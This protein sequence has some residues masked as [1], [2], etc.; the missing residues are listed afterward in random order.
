[1]ALHSQF[2]KTAAT[3]LS[4]CP[5]E[6]NYNCRLARISSLPA[7]K[8]QISTTLLS[9]G[10]YTVALG[11]PTPVVND[12]DLTV[13][14]TSLKDV[15]SKFSVAERLSIKDF[16]KQ[17]LDNHP[18]APSVEIS[19]SEADA[20]HRPLSISQIMAS[21]SRSDSQT[22]IPE[23]EQSSTVRAETGFISK[24]NPT[25]VE[26]EVAGS[27]RFYRFMPCHKGHGGK[28]TVHLVRQYADMVVVGVLAIFLMAVAV[29]ELWTPASGR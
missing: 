16:L 26:E 19:H 23:M 10:L 12:K 13:P 2:W 4:H 7:N 6:Q 18:V 14:T 11:A 27:K 21:P 25:T 17:H 8:M 22:P 9:L 28:Q 1:M 20:M 24:T 5:F 15:L 29:V 3:T